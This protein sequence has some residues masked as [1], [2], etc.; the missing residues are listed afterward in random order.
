MGIIK[1]LI[2]LISE[3]KEEIVWNSHDPQKINKLYEEMI[4]CKEFYATLYQK[5]IAYYLYEKSPFYTKKMD[6]WEAIRFLNKEF[7][8]A[9]VGDS[10]NLK[11]IIRHK[12]Y[13]DEHIL[14][15]SRSHDSVGRGSSNSQYCIGNTSVDDRRGKLIWFTKKINNSL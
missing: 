13:V 11:Y 10:S 6:S 12:A 15:L 7:L 1:G 2:K 8:N 9:G 5:A 14:Y 3:F 4:K